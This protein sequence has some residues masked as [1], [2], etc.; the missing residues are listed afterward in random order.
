MKQLTVNTT[1]HSYDVHIG[2]HAYEKFST[3]YRDRLEQAD[4]IAIIAD[5]HVAETHLD[6]LTEALTFVS[7]KMMTKTIPSGEASKTM[8]TFAD[9]QAFLLQNGC[10]RKSMI[11]AFGGGACGD[12][13]GFVAATFMR[14]IP[15]IQCPTTILAH[16]SAVGGK[17]AIN[18]PEG[19]NMVGAFHQPDAVLFQTPLFHSLPLREIRSGLA[20]LLKHAFISDEQWTI[21]LLAN[22]TFTTPT[23]E[24]LAS[25]LLR[26]IQV[27]ATIVS[28]DEF[29]QG[30][31]KYL[32]FG[33]TFGHAIEAAC[34][35]GKLSHGEAVM[36]GMVYSLLISE[37]L[38]HT[39][40]TLTDQLIRFLKQYHYPLQPINDYSFEELYTFMQKDKKAMDGQVNFVLLNGIGYPFVTSVT[41][42]QCKEAFLQLQQ[43][44]E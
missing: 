27:K 16:D 18:M 44:T 22:D 5:E 35:F 26:G 32:N 12:L 37:Q 31:R 15:F 7:D 38:H 25:Q 33:H 41:K 40:R 42:D 20:E 28:D 29:E 34:G 2:T 19:K 23:D 11:I 39:D 13:A 9:C 24:W 8:A 17:T 4:R 1:Q 3:V 30:T 6:M 43:R 36:I 14:G 10:T 21:E